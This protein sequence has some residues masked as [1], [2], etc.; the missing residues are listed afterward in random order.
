MRRNE[1]KGS[2]YQIIEAH[3]KIIPLQLELTAHVERTPRPQLIA[4]YP[5][6]PCW[7]VKSGQGSNVELIRDLR[8]DSTYQF[9]AGPG[10]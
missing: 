10:S 4:A 3:L 6:G 1:W 2:M 8:I 9:A 5:I 7:S